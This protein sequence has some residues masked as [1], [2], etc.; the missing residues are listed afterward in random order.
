M[1]EHQISVQKDLANNRFKNPEKV[2]E[3]IGELLQEQQFTS[4]KILDDV[5]FIF[6]RLIHLSAVEI[7]TLCRLYGVSLLPWEIDLLYKMKAARI[8]EVSNV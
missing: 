2:M 3:S 1:R 4:P 8:G 6:K 5:L 7:E